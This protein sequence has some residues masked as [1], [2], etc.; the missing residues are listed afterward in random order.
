M[1]KQYAI[2]IPFHS[3]RL[4][5]TGPLVSGMTFVEFVAL[6]NRCGALLCVFVVRCNQD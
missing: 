5:D 1:V 2:L 4:A 3:A 6:Q